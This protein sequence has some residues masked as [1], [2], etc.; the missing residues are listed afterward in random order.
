MIYTS[1]STGK[2]KGVAIAHRNTCAFIEWA[3]SFFDGDSLDRVLAST[4]ICFD[5]SVFELFVPLCRGG[6]VW[7]VGNILDLA[8]A[9]A[10][11][12]PVT[13]INTVPSA[14][15]QLQRSGAIPGTV[16]VINLAGEALQATLV[17]ALYKGAC[18]DRIFNLYGP[19][20]DTT[21]STASLATR[22]ADAFVTIG[23]PIAGTQAYIL[24]GALNLVP[25]GVAG[26]LYLAGEGVARGYLHRPGLTAETFIANPFGQPGSRMYRTGDLVRHLA[27]G[28]IDYL[29]RID[30]QVKIRGF[31][32]EPG[33]IE[34]ALRG[35]AEIRDALV[36]AREDAPGEQRLVAYLVPAGDAAPETGRVRRALQR[37]LPEY[38]VPSHFLVLEKLPLTPS[39]KV[40]R[41]AL[42]PPEAVR[43]E[44]GYVAPCTATQAA[45]AAI[46]ADVLKLDAGRHPRQ[47]LRPGRPFAHGGPRS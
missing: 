43:S 31:R 17:H 24:D 44:T 26:E 21:Y 16:K 4:S 40:D 6:S 27:D 41:K 38:M 13:M 37:S 3:Q 15:A 32:I 19:S 42:P 36:M 35:L 29:G 25:T 47:L 1:G 20:E 2:P 10:A 14:I 34:A 11:D 23:R 12:F 8:S 39:G 18:A 5:L 28:D 30:T 45:L 9:A 46:W 33:E 7:V 22:G